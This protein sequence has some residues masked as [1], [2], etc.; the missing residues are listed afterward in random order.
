MK[1]TREERH[2]KLLFLLED[3]HEKRLPGLFEDENRFSC[4]MPNDVD[5]TEID[6]I[7]CN[8][9]MSERFIDP[10]SEESSSL[11]RC[12][13][14]ELYSLFCCVSREIFGTEKHFDI[15]E[16]LCTHVQNSDSKKHNSAYHLLEMMPNLF[17]CAIYVIKFNEEKACPV[18]SEFKPDQRN[19]DRKIQLTY[20]CGDNFYITLYQSTNKYFHRIA[21]RNVICNCMLERPIQFEKKITKDNSKG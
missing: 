21:G 11:F 17:Q 18:W 3:E 10:A 4:E 7:L 8:P 16:Y 9:F 14:K 13:S 5:K 12:M 1:I 6:S 20:K 2:N 19:D 15:V